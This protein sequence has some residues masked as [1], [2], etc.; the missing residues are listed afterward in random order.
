MIQDLALICHFERT[1]EI[2]LFF[3]IPPLGKGGQFRAS[4]ELDALAYVLDVHPVPRIIRIKAKQGDLVY[5]L[6][7]PSVFIGNPAF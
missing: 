2:H 3:S 1:R 7:F 6:S 4:E 5:R